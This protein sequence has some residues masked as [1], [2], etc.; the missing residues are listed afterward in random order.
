MDSQLYEQCVKV[1][2]AMTERAEAGVWTGHTTYL[3]EELGIGISGYTP[4]IRRLQAMTCIKQM[5]RG[6]RG[7]PSQW[8]LLGE[9]TEDKFL[10]GRPKWGAKDDKIAALEERVAA[11]EERSA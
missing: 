7:I 10:Q 1:Y 4:V 3:F 5:I 11:L 9:P 2:T 6:G 8:E